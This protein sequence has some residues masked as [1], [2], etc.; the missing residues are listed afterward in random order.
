[1]DRIRTDKKLDPLIIAPDT[2]LQKLGLRINL[3][4]TQIFAYLPAKE[5]TPRRTVRDVISI[6]LARL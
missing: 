2:V 4:T 6:S 1:M 3:E 5:A